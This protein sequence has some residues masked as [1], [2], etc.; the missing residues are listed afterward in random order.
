MLHL[1]AAL[2]GMLLPAGLF[3]LITRQTPTAG[4][5]GMPMAT[6]LAFALAVV[7]ILGDRILLALKVFL[8][9]FAL[10]DALDAVLVILLFVFQ[11][12]PDVVL[13]QGKSFELSVS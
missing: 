8:T 2:G 12:D 13:R 1:V 3:W 10:V 9:A 5:W 7:T 4:G 11:L 6:D